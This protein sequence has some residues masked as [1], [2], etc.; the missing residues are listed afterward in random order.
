MAV[1]AFQVGE[2]VEVE[3]VLAAAGPVALVLEL[4]L[5]RKA[6]GGLAHIVELSR[7]CLVR[8][9]FLLSELALALQSRLV[10]SFC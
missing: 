7:R 9:Q 4:V 3:Q 10:V 2:V 6:V 1:Q 5:V 8:Q